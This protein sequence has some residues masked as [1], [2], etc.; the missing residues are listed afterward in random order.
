MIIP[1][2]TYNLVTI[3][4]ARVSYSQ[5][6]AHKEAASGN[7]VALKALQN[8]LV[9]CVSSSIDI[10]I[11]E[12]TCL[13]AMGQEMGMLTESSNEKQPLSDVKK[14]NFE[15][16]RQSL[17]LTNRLFVDFMV[18]MSSS[19]KKY[20]V[21]LRVIVSKQ[22]VHLF[23]DGVV[24]RKVNGEIG[25]RAITIAVHYFVMVDSYARYDILAIT[26][27]V[28]YFVMVDSYARYD[29]LAITI[30]VHYFVMV[31][32]YARYDILGS[33][34]DSSIDVFFNVDST[35]EFGVGTLAGGRYTNPD[36][37]AAVVLDTGTNAEGANAIP[38]WQ[39]LLLKLGE[40]VS[41]F[42]YFTRIDLGAIL[43]LTGQACI[44]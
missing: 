17:Q 4:P 1:A 41:K 10:N 16:N 12:S 5:S 44:F 11:G 23:S 2:T 35:Q 33:W 8:C 26:I 24:V 3:S 30:A 15:A 43:F 7:R 21:F 6:Q 14:E 36:V 42:S 13:K 32:S 38:K 27:A 18:I 37:I 9:P 19:I 28:H 39:G 31:D 34:D 22:V 29:I 40:M 20:N 25:I